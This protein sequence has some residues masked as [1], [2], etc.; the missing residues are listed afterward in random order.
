M[1]LDL[2]IVSIHELQIQVHELQIQFAVMQT[3]IVWIK[4]F[5]WTIIMANAATFLA[6]NV[7]IL[8]NNK[9]DKKGK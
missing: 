6:T 5:V 8:R 7:H 2:I 3:D 4:K 1:D 9:G